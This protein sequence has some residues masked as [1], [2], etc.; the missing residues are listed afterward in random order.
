MLAAEAGWAPVEPGPDEPPRHVELAPSLCA[1]GIT[2][3]DPTSI[4]IVPDAQND[5]RFANNVGSRFLRLWMVLTLTCASVVSH[6]C[7]R[8]AAYSHSTLRPVRNAFLPPRARKH[9]R[10]PRC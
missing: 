2:R 5:W 6:T 3:T 1:H 7:S 10:D 8:M 9:P 4:F